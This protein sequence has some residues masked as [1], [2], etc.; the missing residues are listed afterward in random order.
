M[1]YT[2]ITKTGKIM[3]FFVQA[4]AELYQQ[5]NGG[6]VITEEIL[7]DNKSEICYNNGIQ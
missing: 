2:L 1:K 4:T 7:V 6:V 5:I 3:Q